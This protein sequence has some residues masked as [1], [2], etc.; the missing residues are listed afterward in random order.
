MPHW[1]SWLL[2]LVRDLLKKQ[3]YSYFGFPLAMELDQMCRM[4]I[5]MML[6]H[7][8]YLVYPHNS[9]AHSFAHCDDIEHDFRH[10]YPWTRTKCE[11]WLSKICN[12]EISD[13]LRNA[14]SPIFEFL[15][16]WQD[17]IELYVFALCLMSRAYQLSTCLLR[18]AYLGEQGG[19]IP[20]HHCRTNTTCR[21]QNLQGI[22]TIKGQHR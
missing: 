22:P 16:L 20:N 12:E 21:T 17:L 9:I 18:V 6:L 2:Q 10:G 4:R 3:N 19:C 7:T 13:Y 8:K 14:T 1:W 11:S 5:W 15:M